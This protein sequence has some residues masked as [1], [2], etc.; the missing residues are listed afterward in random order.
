M[1]RL[2]GLNATENP[3]ANFIADQIDAFIM[4][5]PHQESQNRLSRLHNSGFPS[6][7]KIPQSLVMKISHFEHLKAHDA[8]L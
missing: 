4:D 7:P 8:H 3:E 6:K 1:A 5:G 2:A